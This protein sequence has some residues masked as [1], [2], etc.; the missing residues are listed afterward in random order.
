[1]FSGESSERHK[2]SK[3]KKK[4]KEKDRERKHKHHKEKKRHRG[5]DSSQ[6]DYS[7]GDE[8]SQPPPPETMMFYQSL[9]TANSAASVPVTKP[10]I[11]IKKSPEPETQHSEDIAGPS[12]VTT[13]EP[14]MSPSSVHS[15]ADHFE[16]SQTP[17][18]PSSVDSSGREPRSCVLKMKQS[19][20]P[21]AKLLDHLL[22]GLE[23]KDPQQYF[24]WPVTDDIAPGYSTIITKPMDFSTI[25]QKI[26]DNEY[27]TLTEFTD[28][29]KLMCENAIKYNHAETVYHKAAKKLLHVGARYLQPESLIKSLKPLMIYMRELS[30][31]E[32]G[33]ELPSSEHHDSIEGNRMTLRIIYQF[34]F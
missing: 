23:K 26:D 10:F 2:K 34:S 24:A 14:M 5:D 22:R 13:E 6:E 12:S 20:S 29:F 16:S 4:K 32:L 7:F 9:T 11:P 25:R 18:T 33:F 19:R 31:K 21:L 17:K 15:A 28:D 3:K 30:L 27:K 8:S 1:M